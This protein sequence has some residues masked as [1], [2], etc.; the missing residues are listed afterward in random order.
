[1]YQFDGRTRLSDH[2]AVAP[3][4]HHDN[5]RVEIDSLFR[6]PILE[7]ART[8]FVCDS[9]ENAVAHKLAQAVG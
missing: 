6:Q 7:S 5:Q 8:F 4:H 1:M 3:L 9:T 2:P